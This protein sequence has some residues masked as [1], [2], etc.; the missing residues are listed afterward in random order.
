MQI[1]DKGG[2]CFRVLQE[3]GEMSY[4]IT[5][6]RRAGLTVHAIKLIEGHS[7]RSHAPTGR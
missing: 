4:L 7:G 6:H 2:L 3:T 5:A 1:I